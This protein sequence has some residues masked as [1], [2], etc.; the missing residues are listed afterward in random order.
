MTHSGH[1]AGRRGDPGPARSDAAHGARQAVFGQRLLE[2][3]VQRFPALGI[4]AATRMV[5]RALVAVLE[6]YQQADGS[7]LEPD[8]LRPYMGGIEQL[9]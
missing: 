2:P 4:A 3:L 5:G 6:N 8:V 7:V 1:G 9:K